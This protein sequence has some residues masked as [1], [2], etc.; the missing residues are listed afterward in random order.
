MDDAQKECDSGIKRNLPIRRFYNFLAQRA[1]SV[2]IFAALFCTLAV[3]LFHSC[4]QGYSNDYFGWILADIAVLLGIEVVLAVICF[5]WPKR[6]VIRAATIIA[7]IICTWSVM[8]AG[9]VIRTGT[10]I[11]PSN[12]LPL[13]RDPLNALCIIGINLIKMPVA[14]VILLGPSAIALTFFFCALVKAQPLGYSHSY[15]NNKV[16]ISCIIILAALLARGLFD[17]RGSVEI[18]TATLRYNSQLKAVRTLFSFDFSK[19]AKADITKTLRKI[20]SFDEM[21]IL[22]PPEPLRINQNVIIVVLEGVQY[23]YT[24]MANPNNNLTSHLAKL[25]KEGVEFTNVYSTVTH[26]TKALFSLLTGRYPCVYQDLAE[27]VPALQPY[28][29]LAM[30]LKEKLDYRT[31]FFQS[32]KGNFEARPGLVYNLGFDKFWAR[33]NLNDPNTY[34]GYLGSDEFSMLKPIVEWLETN[35]QGK[36]FFLTILCSVTHDPYEVPEWFAKPAKDSVERYRQAIFYT[37]KFIAALDVELTK[38]NLTNKTIFCV[39]GDHGEAFGEHNQLGHERIAFE[40]ALKIPW[41]MRAHSLIV[42]ETKINNAVSSIDLTP[43]LLALLGFDSTGCSFDGNNVLEDKEQIRKVY[44]SGWMKEAPAGFIE[45][46][47]KFVYNPITETTSVYDLKTDPLELAG[48]QLDEEKAD[49]ITEDIN[50]WRRSSFFQINQLQSSRKVLFNCW[51]C[52]WNNRVCTAK[53]LSK[54]EKSNDQQNTTEK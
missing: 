33:D 19:P 7:A 51:L 9:W 35:E 13:V 8:N 54:A 11:L 36:P 52:R 42:P 43:T 29:S 48:T 20:P 27:A 34:V 41:V 30:I 37:D 18:T 50:T 49:I 17:N 40:E 46:N 6:R 21:Q 16:L 3:K 14:S 39:V 4:R 32:A 15:L 23:Q 12:L 22:P 44:F 26:T 5:R 25:A 53:Y 47:Q 10:Q 45:G 38:R 31:A 28:A 24:S 2:I 1:F